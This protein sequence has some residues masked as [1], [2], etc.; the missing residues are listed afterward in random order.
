MILTVFRTTFV[1]VDFDFISY[2]GM[3]FLGFRIY[4]STT[5]LAYFFIGNMSLWPQAVE[6]QR[7]TSIG[8]AS[9]TKAI[10]IY[11]QHLCSTCK[12]S[13]WV[14]SGQSDILSN[15][16]LLPTNRP[17]N[18]SIHK[19]KNPSTRQ[20]SQTPK[21]ILCPVDR[22]QVNSYKVLERKSGYVG[23]QT[24][25]AIQYSLYEPPPWRS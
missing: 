1:K 11:L 14:F 20:S 12:F 16:Q 2:A 24:L 5:Q 8:H 3:I 18:N 21:S 13:Q 19:A 9:L 6:N 25:L 15:E 17:E 10:I 23:L 4:C 22:N 7:L